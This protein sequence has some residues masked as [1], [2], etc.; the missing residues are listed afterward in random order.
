MPDYHLAQINIGRM[1]APVDSDIM[2]GFTSR[3]DEIN[4][5]ADEAEGFVWRLQT[6][7]GDATAIRPYDDDMMIVN[8][9]VWETYEALHNYTY[10]T[11][12]VELIKGRKDWFEKLSKPHMVLWWIPAGHI[13]TIDEAIAKLDALE[14]HGSTPHA[15]S[16]AK[17]VTVEDWLAM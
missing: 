7:D 10:K 9:S 2:H 8:M 5:L 17:P 11:L 13:P 3:L 1:L 6:E 16:F 15:F 14:A 4:A 12:H